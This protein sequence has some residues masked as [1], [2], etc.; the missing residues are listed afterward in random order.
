MGALTTALVIGAAGQVYGAV[1][2]R[3][4]GAANRR[5]ADAQARDVIDAGEFEAT[6]YE[7]EVSQLLGSQRAIF[8]ASGVDVNQGSAKALRAQT[9]AIGA[10][11]AAQIRLNAARQAWGIRTQGRLDQ[12]AANNR[13]VVGM[14]AGAS[15]LLGAG[16]DMWQARGLA[17]GQRVRDAVASSSRIMGTRSRGYTQALQR[18][19]LGRP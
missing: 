12:Q 5:F 11:D 17:Q 7:Q 6:R 1:A 19:Y 15:T 14:A 2:E 3:K 10:E 9:E 4:A 18:N 8:G 13:S 16:V